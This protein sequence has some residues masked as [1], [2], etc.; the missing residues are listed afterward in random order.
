[1]KLTVMRVW[2]KDY[3][4]L[5]AECHEPRVITDDPKAFIEQEKERHGSNFGGYHVDGAAPLALYGNTSLGVIG[6]K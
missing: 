2:L 4:L 1:M 3:N 6:G 5:D